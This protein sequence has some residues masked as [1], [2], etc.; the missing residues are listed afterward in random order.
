[1]KKIIFLAFSM[2]LASSINLLFAQHPNIYIN[3]S[4][5]AAIKQ[6]V[7]DNQEPWKSA[8]TKWMELADA[9]L[10][11]KPVSV[12]YGGLNDCNLNST[13]FCTGAYYAEDNRDFYDSDE[14]VKPITTAIRDLGMGYALTGDA[15]YAEKAISLFRVFALDPTTGMKP[16]FTNNQSRISIAPVMTGLIYGFDLMFNYEGWDA[17][18][19]KAT[20]DWIRALANYARPRGWGNQ[21]FGDWKI[22]FISAAGVFCEDQSLLD[23]A[24]TE[25]KRLIPIQIGGDGKMGQEAGRLQGGLHYSLYALLA[26]T[27]VAEVARHQGIDLYN[28]KVSGTNKGLELAY[29]F[30][31]PYVLNPSSWDF[32]RVKGSLNAGKFFEISY[33]IFGK[34]KYLDVINSYGRPLYPSIF[35]VGVVTLTHAKGAYSAGFEPNVLEPVIN[36]NGGTFESST[37]VSITSP[38]AEASV[39]YTTDGSTPTATSTLYTAPFTLN[40]SATVRAIAFKNEDQSN[41]ASA[42]FT[43]TAPDTTPP[44]LISAGTLSDPTKVTVLFSEA[45][46]ETSAENTANY[47]LDGGIIVTGA[48][49]GAD[50]KTVTLTVSSL[51]EDNTYA[52][53]VSN[54]R[55]R[56]TTPNT[57]VSNSQ[58]SFV[59]ALSETSDKSWQNFPMASQNGSFTVTFDITPNQANMDGITGLSFGAASQYSDAAVIV[60]LNSSGRIDARN[61]GA[62]KADNVLTY[63]AGTKYNVRLAIDM[64][65][66]TYTIYGKP[67]G[68]SEVTIG[69]NFAFR[70]Q[71]STVSVLNNWTLYANT[72]SHTVGNFIINGTASSVSNPVIN[73][74]GGTFQSSAQVSITSPTSGAAIWYT[75]DGSTPTDTSTLYA[76]P[77]TLTTSGTVKAIAFKDT[78][79]SSITSAV[80][81]INTVADS[82]SN[83]VINPNGG[84]FESSTQVSITS[85]T[86]GAAIWYTTDGS[87]PTDTSILYTAPFTLTTSATVKAIAFK[88]TEQ[89]S[90]TSAAFTI[91][92]V[93]DSVSNPIINPNG[94][95]FEDLAQ[96]SITSP[97][98]GA[99]IWY[100]TDGSTPTDTS[101]LYAAPFTLTTSGTVK[102][103]A[104]KDTEKSSITSAVFTIN[105]VADSVS[106][107]VI[108]PNGGSFEDLAQISITSPTSGASIRY[109]TDGSAPTTTST[110]YAAPFTLT[111]SATVK[112]IAFKDTEKSSI[113]SATFTITPSDTTPP[114]LVSASMLNDPTKVIVLFSEAVEEASAENTANYMLD[115][116]IDVT[117]ASLGADFKTVT[118]TVSSLTEGTYTLT[119]NNVRD[120]ATIPNTIVS[121][122]KVS[123]GFTLFETSGKF[124]QNFPITSQNGSFT[125][126]FDITPNQA[127]MDGITGLSFGSASQYS[128]VAVIVRLNSSG[129]IDAR[130][131]GAYKA[132]NVLAYTAGTKYNVRLAIDMATRT[133]T[134]YAKPEGG[135]EVTIGTN[136]AFRSQQSTVSVLNNWTLYANTGSHTVG[137][138]IIN[139]T[140]SSVSNPVINPN[141]GTFESSAQVS[142]TSSTSGAAIRYTTD[143]S[144]PTDTSTLYAAPF[145]LT[146]STTVKAIAFK[147]TEKSSITSAVFTIT[148]PDTAPPELVSAS[149]LNDP[150]KLIVLFSEDVE[151]ASAENTANYTL[152][153][154]INVAGAS[155]GTD[156][157]T[158]TL[159]V[160]SLTEG[161][162]TLTVNNVRDRA[163][164]PNTIVSNSQASFVVTL[165]ETSGKFWQNF[166]ITSQNGSFTATF[167]ITPNQANMD[168]ITGLSFGSASQ[169]SNVAVIVRLNSSGRI[170]ARNGG[171]YKADNVLAYT[172]GTK[173]NVRLAI[174]MATRTYTIYAKPE[175]GSEVTIGT[176]FAFRSQQSTVSVLDNWTMYAGIGS[177][178]VGNFIIN[179]STSSVSNLDI[180]NGATFESSDQV[181]TSTTVE[182]MTTLNVLQDLSGQVVFQFSDIELNSTNFELKVFNLQGNLVGD[183][184]NNTHNA[185]TV[186]SSS[187]TWNASS[188]RSGIY[189]VKAIIGNKILTQRILLNR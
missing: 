119:V 177:H 54:V 26:L 115:G 185:S 48:S 58:V 78:E 25:F 111:T 80:F 121:N 1:M 13:Y 187:V 11:Q 183:L 83:P 64:A 93:A 161:T 96:V 99:A 189:I 101:T 133:Y 47:M 87:T 113:T 170:D 97:T 60:R 98:S 143:G 109:T 62:Y 30:M 175:G 7:K 66:R 140:A 124:W 12:T 57:I 130:N 176:N 155:L 160:S 108:N 38:A 19:K 89:S 117:G 76:A 73:P 135:A 4:E 129:R 86:S 178:T 126:T 153:G 15:K 10:S 103:I 3:A 39:R 32:S 146:T 172:A 31:A 184:S 70:S 14:V 44:E 116:G 42:V 128:N 63:T 156:F 94:G 163:T 105:T 114:E 182:K 34:S 23:Y 22:A 71:Q 72:G 152:D 36:P 102:A 41:I 84:T 162:Y 53:T 75:T 95:V 104:F 169:Y 16:R 61:G 43:I 6:K 28:Y 74:N 165:S 154:G 118:L 141:G 5:L 148:V 171:A 50:F 164:T 40:A 85:S 27:Q 68:G 88:A 125:V 69:S 149:T 2:L 33:L 56:A 46:E 18:E 188:Y 134:I 8:H 167:D 159:T 132:D 110:L 142:I 137:N 138:F 131:G 67:E 150:T 9:A 24:F 179:G 123:F 82:V 79:K 127:N 100:T 144:T 37:Q 90:I 151:E 51:T 136:F 55:D 92:V 139:G 17:A 20:Q 181:S 35:G 122:S 77:F 173:Y 158:V 166:P 107:P 147:A 157:K 168:G 45:V 29:D 174:D 52:L 106:R 120:R 186:K 112:A 21:N 65:T 49:L 81:T 145:T 91:N 59:A 180:N